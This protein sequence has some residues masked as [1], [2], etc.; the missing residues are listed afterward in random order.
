MSQNGGK[1][2]QIKAAFR[3]LLLSNNKDESE[4]LDEIQSLLLNR[5]PPTTLSIRETPV[6]AVR[7]IRRAED[8]YVYDIGMANTNKP[9]YFGNDILVHNSSYF[10]AWPII[11]DSVEQGEME[12]N[13]D[14]AISLYDSIADKVNDSFALFAEKAFHCPQSRGTVLKCGREIVASKGLYITKKRYAVL[15]YDKDGKRAD[16]ET[17]P[18]KIKAMGLDL[19]RSDTP[20]V[21]QK[22]LYELLHDVLTGAQREHVVEKVLEFKKEFKSQ[23]P[24]LKGSPKRV[25][26][27]TSYGAK[28][29]D[30]S[31]KGMIPGHVR[32]S[33]NWNVLRSMN[34]DNRTAKI[35]DGMKVIVCKLRPN[36]MGWTSIAYPTDEQHLPVW[37]KELPFDSDLMESTVVDQKVNNLLGVLDW[38]IGDA[39]DLSTTFQSLFEF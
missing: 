14:L 26:N 22:F 9:W 12:W 3:V 28:A 24:W 36:P 23:D 10:S 18:G 29:A 33:L 25:N 37:F 30:E 38:E 21:I 27:M 2:N 17:S 32:G 7:K 6:K 8:E 1:N 19:K 39:T 35:V 16:S 4:C 13:R 20:K 34:N 31:Y 5:D 15:Y 11:K